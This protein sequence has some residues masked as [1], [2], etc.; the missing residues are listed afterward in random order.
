MKKLLT[1]CFLLLFLAGNVWA[2]EE[3]SFRGVKFGM[4]PEEVQA[5]ET[6]ILDENQSLNGDLFYK[7]EDLYGLETH[8]SYVFSNFHT[9]SN[10]KLLAIGL[11]LLVPPT[12]DHEAKFADI[13]T[14]VWAKYGGG[15]EDLDKSDTWMFFFGNAAFNKCFSVSVDL[16]NARVSPLYEFD[17]ED[18]YHII[19][20]DFKL[21]P[22]SR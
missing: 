22:G 12:V 4:S 19:Y 15:D 1:L 16:N 21:C 7:T 8:I 9:K 10:D 13:T 11:Y 6:G 5:I 17:E 14:D 18:G 2:T 20:V 3:F